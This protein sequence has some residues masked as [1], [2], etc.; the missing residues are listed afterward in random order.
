MFTDSKNDH[1]FKKMFYVFLEKF[2]RV[3]IILFCKVILT[4]SKRVEHL[5]NIFLD[6]YYKYKILL[7]HVKIQNIERYTL[8][9]DTMFFR[10]NVVF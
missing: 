2:H 3:L 10:D 7:I 6:Y 1:A 5:V 8:N 4:F 9:E